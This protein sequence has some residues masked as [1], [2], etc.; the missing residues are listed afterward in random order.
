MLRDE[1][2]LL[3]GPSGQIGFP[4]AEYLSRENEVWGVAR[5]GDAT[6]RERVDAARCHHPG[7]RPRLR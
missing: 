7:L 3:T 5:F 2:I 4:L 6:A 1:K